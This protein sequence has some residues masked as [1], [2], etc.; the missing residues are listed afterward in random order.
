MGIFSSPN[1]A[2]LTVRRT[3]HTVLAISISVEPGTSLSVEEAIGFLVGCKE[4]A[5][6]GRGLVHEVR[7]VMR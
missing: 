5:N 3:P 6:V 1:R 7:F 2:H 4:L